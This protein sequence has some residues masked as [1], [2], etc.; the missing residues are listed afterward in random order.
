MRKKQAP[1]LV[2]ML[3]VTYA[4][5]SIT[6]TPP[7]PTITPTM[8][9]GWSCTL[10]AVV[11]LGSATPGKELANQ[12]VNLKQISN[13]SPTRGEQE[14]T[15]GT[16]GVASFEIYLHDTDSFLFSVTADGYQPAEVKLG[17]FDCLYCSCPPVEII[18]QP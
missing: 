6:P 9:T 5:I 2:I 13:C 15:T 1:I 8:C 4:C 11:Y 12:P 14:I 17:G 16:D 7:P 10:Q 3:L 18:L